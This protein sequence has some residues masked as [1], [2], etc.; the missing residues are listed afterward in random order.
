MTGFYFN[1]SSFF[2]QYIPSNIQ[3]EQKK[4]AAFATGSIIFK[5]SYYI[6][7]NC[8]FCWSSSTLSLKRLS[9]S[10][11]SFTVWQL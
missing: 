10:I 8:T 1:L 3:K 9:V 2:I 6:A 11:K 5:I 4:P 7:A